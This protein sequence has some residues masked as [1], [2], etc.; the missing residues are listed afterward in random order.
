MTAS[1]REQYEGSYRAESPKERRF[2]GDQVRKGEAK[3][4]LGKPAPK[5]DG[6]PK[7][8]NRWDLTPS[9]CR[10][11]KKE[12]KRRHLHK[13]KLDRER[14]GEELQLGRPA[15]EDEL[16]RHELAGLSA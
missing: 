1:S 16:A 6:R 5:D 14:V 11:R 15:T 13:R 7:E 8:S 12:F 3:L 2:I 9:E 4:G 10:D